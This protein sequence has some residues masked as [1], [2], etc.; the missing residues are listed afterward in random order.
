[1]PTDKNCVNFNFKFTILMKRSYI[2]ELSK[3][4]LRLIEMYILHYVYNGRNRQ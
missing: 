1:M 2:I 3:T 4:I